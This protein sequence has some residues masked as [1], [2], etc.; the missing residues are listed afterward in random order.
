MSALGSSLLAGCDPSEMGAPSTLSSPGAAGGNASARPKRARPRRSTHLPF[1]LDQD[2]TWIFRFA[3]GGKEAELHIGRRQL[4][5]SDWH[6]TVPDEFAERLRSPELD[7]PRWSGT[8]F[9]LRAGKALS[10]RRKG[11]IVR[12]RAVP[13]L[14]FGPGTPTLPRNELR[15]GLDGPE[16]FALHLTGQRTWTA[17]AS[18]PACARGSVTGQRVAGL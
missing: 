10:R 15:I 6:V 14:P 13:S 16:S 1:R 11:V 5:Q 2:D 9:L 17:T 18:R 4:E 12:F 7:S 3:Y 8:R